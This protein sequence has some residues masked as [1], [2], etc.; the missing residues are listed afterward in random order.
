MPAARQRRAAVQPKTSPPLSGAVFSMTG[1]AQARETSGNLTLTVTLKAVNHRFLDL[2]WQ[3]PA[4]LEAMVSA[5]EKR[6]RVAI[7]RGHVDVRLNYDRPFGAAAAV[8]DEQVLEGYL[9]AHAEL[10]ERLNLREPPAISELLRLPGVMAPALPAPAADLQA[11]LEKAFAA[12]LEQLNRMRLAEGAAL[13]TDLLARIGRIEAARDAV[14]AHRRQLESGYL[15]RLRNRLEELLAGAAP[16]QER[17]LQEAALLAER[18]DVSEELTRIQAH[19]AQFR[20]L[21]AGGGEVGKK[22][23][24]LAQE[25][26]REINTLLSK[27]ADAAP[28]ALRISE[29]G[30]ELK[31]ELEKIREQIQNLE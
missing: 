31:A 10:S 25:L 21:L 19:A 2:R 27:T 23:D 30:L 8:L 20:A 5:L 22:L 26:N 17:L 29:L 14:A 18:G 24:F 11:P 7:R 28:P 3:A 16:P 4:E 1:Y 9:S 6:L 13:T 12:A 15:D